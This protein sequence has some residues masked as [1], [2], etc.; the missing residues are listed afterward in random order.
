[1]SKILII[2][3]TISLRD[4]ISF[5]LTLEGYETIFADDG[6]SGIEMAL[7]H[8]P[9]LILCDIVMPGM[10]GYEVLN[11]LKST[12]GYLC[13]PFI[14]ITALSERKNFREGMELGAD[15]YLVKPFSIDE[16]I[17]AIH[18]QLNK[19]NTLESRILKQIEAIEEQL[20]SR[21]AELEGENELQKNLLE[22]ISASHVKIIEQFAEKQAQ[23]IQEALRSIEINANL[24]QMDKQLFEEI[25]N[26]NISEEYRKVL[27]ALRNKIRKR[28]VITNNWTIFQIKFDIT[29]PHIK[30]ILAKRFPHLSQQEYVLF[31]G[32]YT[33]LNANQLATILN[34]ESTSIRKYKYRLKQKLGLQKEDSLSGFI[35]N[36]GNS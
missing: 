15:D 31:S 16:L 9:D 25:K 27:I 22:D 14:F 35:Y 33:K 5:S 18:T 23:L 32:I 4:Q 11:R 10:D 12:E 7:N 30:D 20:K 1:M 36:I 29:F 6:E 8:H 17:N 21:I 19:H 34:V 24:Q 13:C 2:E 26:K 28:S 3:D